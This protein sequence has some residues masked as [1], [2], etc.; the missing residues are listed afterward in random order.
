MFSRQAREDF[1]ANHLELRIAHKDVVLMMTIALTVI[2]S[3]T[4]NAPV[5]AAIDDR[6]VF[7]KLRHVSI[8]VPPSFINRD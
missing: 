2:S 5:N 4:T 3:R 8:R 6:M 1:P 7:G